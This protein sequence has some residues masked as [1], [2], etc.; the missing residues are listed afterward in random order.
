MRRPRK[1]GWLVCALLAAGATAVAAATPAQQCEAGKNKAAGAYAACRHAAAS[2]FA[3]KHDAAKLAAALARCDARQAKT[4]SQL[5]AR[6]VQHGGACPSVGDQLAVQDLIGSETSTVAASLAGG[7]LLGDVLGAMLQTGETTCFAG[8]ETPTPCPGTGQDGELQKG[9]ARAYRDNGDGTITDRKTGLTWEKESADGSIHDGT[10]HYGWTAAFGKLATLNAASF[11]GHTD[12]RLPNVVEMQSIMDYGVVQSLSTPAVAPAFDIG[13][14]PGCTVL[15]CSCNGGF[16]YWTSTT[17]A[18]D[19]RFAWS[20]WFQDG[21]M[22]PQF[23]TNPL[24]VRAVR[25]GL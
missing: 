8:A 19:R 18:G 25:G 3:L 6:T 15:A 13:C 22:T 4:W 12:W 21:V 17:T 1:I 11:A 10:I 24:A 9:L 20:G 7:P 14:A 23:K 5:E 2:G 16:F